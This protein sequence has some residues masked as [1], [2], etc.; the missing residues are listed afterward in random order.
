VHAYEPARFAQV[1]TPQ[2]DPLA[3]SFT[4]AHVAASPLPC[5]WY[6]AAHEHMNPPEVFVQLPAPAEAPQVAGVRHSSTS[7]HDAVLPLPV[8]ANPAPHVQA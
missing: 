6:P 8:A 3:H 5:A 1:P 4:S 7:A 2:T